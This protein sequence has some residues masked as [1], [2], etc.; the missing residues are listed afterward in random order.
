MTELL[1]QEPEHRGRAALRGSKGCLAVLVA[2]A[3]LVTGG[4]FA[5]N[6]ASGFVQDLVATPDYTEPKGA[7]D[8][9]VKVP[10]GA[11]LTQIGLELEKV[12][13]IK[14]TKAFNQAIEEYEG[15]PVVQ[16]GKYKMRTQLPATNA[17]DRL[18]APKKYRITVQFQVVEGLR[19]S[20]QVPAL[21]KATKIPAKKYQ[22]ALKKPDSLGLPGYA[23]GRPEGFLFPDTYELTDEGSASTVLKQMTARFGAVSNELALEEQ[24]AKLDID[25]YQLV[26]IAS[27]VESEVR[28]PED[29]AKVARVIYNRLDKKMP[30]QMDSTVHYAVN[31][32]DKVTTTAADRKNKSPYNTYV[33]KG[34][35]P[36]PIAAP[37]AAALKAAADPAG[38]DWLYFVTVN[39][40]TGETKFGKTKAEHDA[41]VKEFQQWCSKNSGRC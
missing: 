24:A 3:I 21:A 26:I 28:N 39:P 12:D 40:E 7:A 13:V 22:A 23:K 38:G 29:R 2:L 19:L 4:Y 8:I 20:E 6:K 18:T 27:I 41:Y 10:E 35:P 5:W 14:S 17:L 31:K 36:G 1:D 37:G 16:A 15:N 34:L 32:S 30:L 11:N 25:P 9:V 33:H